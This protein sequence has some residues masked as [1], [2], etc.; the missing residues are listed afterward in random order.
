MLLLIKSCA[1]FLHSTQKIER[2]RTAHRLVLPYFHNAS[3]GGSVVGQNY[4]QWLNGCSWLVVFIAGSLQ[5]K[6]QAEEGQHSEFNSFLSWVLSLEKRVGRRGV[7]ASLHCVSEMNIRVQPC[8]RVGW[9]EEG[10]PDGGLSHVLQSG[11]KTSQV[12]VCGV[13]VR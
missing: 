3:I 10:G 11:G 7:R 13:V 8:T 1:L 5:C 4:P 6:H 2:T 9:A 12:V